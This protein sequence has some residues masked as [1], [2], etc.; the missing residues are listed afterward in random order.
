M[1]SE[2]TL[3][4]AV[5]VLTFA[6]LAVGGGHSVPAGAFPLLDSD[7]GDSSPGAVTDLAAPDAAA[8]RHQLQLANGFGAPAGGGWTILPRLSLEEIFNDN[9]QQ[10]NQPR[11]SD[12]MTLI[13]PGLSVAGDLPR[14]QIKFDYAP[15]VE[16]NVPEGSQ[17]SLI[18]QLNGTALLTAVEDYAYVDVRAMAGVQS[19]NGLAGS[20]G[21]VGD[22][23]AIGT[24]NGLTSGSSGVGLPKDDRLQ[25]SSF[26]VSPYLM[27]TFGDWGTARIGTSLVATAQDQTG[28]FFAAPFPSGGANGSTETSMEQ[29]GQF[30]TGSFLTRWQDEVDF[31]LMRTTNTTNQIVNATGQT[32][33]IPRTTISSNRAI[34]SDK[35]TYA[36]THWAQTFVTF[37]HEDISYSNTSFNRIDDITW[38]AGVTVEPNPDSDITVSYGHQNGANSIQAAG[39]YALTARTTIAASYGETLGTQLEQVGQ[40][41]QVGIIG[42]NGQFIDGANG[43]PLLFNVYALQVV[44]EVFR[45]RTFSFNAQT[46]LDR[47]SFNLTAVVSQQTSAGGGQQLSALI[48][49]ASIQWNHAVSADLSLS[50]YAAYTTQATSNGE[51]CF[52]ASNAVCTGGGS[53]LETLV[54][55][56]SVNYILTETLTANLRYLF[57]DR[58]SSVGSQSMYQ[59]LIILGVT[60]SF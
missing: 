41:L 21:A 19:V 27:H 10:V 51:S 16:V 50:A 36:V 49:S 54:F 26:S 32:T 56:A 1:P 15:G 7:S 24:D 18:Q 2:R 9:V 14:L 45:Y 48:K 42:P 28:G 40:Q 30:T 20:N 59:D 6:I 5:A 11:Q 35:L 23:G 43:L 22:A 37:G 33:A 25:T 17:N 57:S 46:V 58:I 4:R 3:R 55:G 12:F 13:S 34:F 53:S 31:D 52:G 60:K 8:L 38:G 29:S 39:H 44:P 47:D